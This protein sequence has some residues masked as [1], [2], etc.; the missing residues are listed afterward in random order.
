[1]LRKAWKLSLVTDD[2]TNRLFR[3]AIFSTH[4]ERS[5]G[6][7]ESSCRDFKVKRLSSEVSWCIGLSVGLEGVPVARFYQEL[8]PLLYIRG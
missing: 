5:G 6:G 1:M 4:E 2:R 3:V 7:V 8:A